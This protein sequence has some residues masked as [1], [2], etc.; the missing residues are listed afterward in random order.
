MTNLFEKLPE[1]DDRKFVIVLFGGLL[2]RVTQRSSSCDY[3]LIE[4]VCFPVVKRELNILS[5]P[6]IFQSNHAVD[7]T[8]HIS[9]IHT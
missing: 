3:K 4:N 7:A 6:I 9:K 2:I 8:D 1:R 5:L